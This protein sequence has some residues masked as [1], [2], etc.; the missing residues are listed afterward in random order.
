MTS[1]HDSNLDDEQLAA[2]EASEPAIAVLAG[3]GSGKTRT[4]SHRVR[5]L[6]S[7]NINDAALLLTFTNKAAA[8]MKARAVATAA[9]TSNRLQ[10]STFHTFCAEVLRSHGE[11]VGLSS[12]FEIVEASEANRIARECSNISGFP[13]KWS[14]ARLRRL[15]VPP[16]IAEAGNRYELAKRAENIV[17]FDDLVVYA[18]HILEQHDDVTRAFAGRFPH[19]LVDEFQDTNAVQAAL[20]HALAVH[21]R[22]VSIF[23]DDD[24]AIFGFAGAEAEN[25]HRFVKRAGAREYPLARNY[26]SGRVI[27]DVANAL[28]AA[29]PSASGRRMRAAREGGAVEH[30]TYATAE[31]EATDIAG[32]IARAVGAGTPA[33]A[34]AVLARAG[35][36]ADGILHALKLHS[37]PVSD[38]RGETHTS[39]GRRLLAA[40]LA[41]VRGTLNAR[42]TQVLCGLMGVDATGKCDTEAFLELH[43]REPLAQGLNRMR[44]LVFAGATAHDLARAARE[45]VA[46]QRD[47]FGPV[48]DDMVESVRHFQEYDPEF[49]VEHLLAELA[50]GSIGRAPTEGGGVKIASLHRTK[51][52]QWATVYLVGL[53]EGHLPDSR[54][55]TEKELA[56]ERRLCFVG[57]SRA[58]QRLVIT[59][60]G[61]VRGY[62][63]TPSRFLAE[64]K[65]GSRTQ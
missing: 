13:H 11:L 2:V 38:W 27:V 12:D 1:S 52:L 45:A 54:S 26:R 37:L 40:C 55:I 51:G 65:L 33:S 44:D 49:S 46:A 24:Q 59:R 31:L 62:A 14:N 56:E 18:A 8:E 19:I 60:C 58:E 64:M 4:L 53:E 9:V 36:R 25:I 21:A 61:I 3:P 29:S 20:I 48:L 7:E 17:D 50:L 28:I 35:R 30:Q 47:A 43:A 22:T 63:C 41:T 42:Q 34:I 57:V 16:D 23:A 10:A 6:L 15:D 5:H 32:Q 39:E